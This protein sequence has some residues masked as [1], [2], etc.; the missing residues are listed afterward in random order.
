MA[1]M[2][3]TANP[4]FNEICTQLECWYRSPLGQF[5]YRQERELTE[6]LLKPLH[7]HRLLQLGVS[8][9]QPLHSSS[10]FPQ[11]MY[12]SQSTDGGIDLCTELARLPFAS[13]SVDLLVL[14]HT[15]EFSSNPHQLLHEANRILAHRGHLI[16]LGFNPWSLFG[17]GTRAC[18]LM[19]H[20]L[21]E[22]AQYVSNRRLRDWLRLLGLD[23]ESSRY[24]IGLPPLGRGTLHNILYTCDEFLTRKNLP[25]G[26]VHI[27]HAQK[28]VAGMTADKAQWNRRVGSRLIGLTVAKPVASPR[29][30]IRQ[31]CIGENQPKGKIAA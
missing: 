9:E 11:K 18:G 21:W 8:R 22:N 28:Q 30:A 23:V 15:I 27:I 3:S 19:K 1:A 25:V 6:N 17:L 5:V 4:Q 10:H 24:C 26:G 13:E 16:I 29:A 31:Y 7:G 20:P 14:H 12:A 2:N